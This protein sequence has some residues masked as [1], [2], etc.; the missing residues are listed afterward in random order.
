MYRITVYDN[1]HGERDLDLL[2]SSF[3]FNFES[4]D[5]AQLNDSTASWSYTITLPR[6]KRNE[7]V[8]GNA[9]MP[10]V[11]ALTPYRRVSCNVYADG[12]RIIHAGVLVID[13]TT[14]TEYKTQILAGTASV[15]DLMKA[16]DFKNWSRATQVTLPGTSLPANTTPAAGLKY[17]YPMPTKIAVSGNTPQMQTKEDD[18]YMYATPL[19][20]IGAAANTG[21]LN[22]LMAE[23]GYSFVTDTPDSVLDALWLSMATRK[24]SSNGTV[25]WS[26]SES[27]VGI[28]NVITNAGKSRR[29]HTRV[30]ARFTP[31]AY[32]DS[33]HSRISTVSV[34]SNF[35]S[36]GGSV[37][38]SLYDQNYVPG[39]PNT[40]LAYIRS[41]MFSASGNDIVATFDIDDS[42]PHTE[43]KTFGG[44][45][46]T[47]QWSYY[48]GSQMNYFTGLT[49]SSAKWKVQTI[50][51]DES[52]TA[53]SGQQMKL[54]P[55]VGIANGMDFF[56]ILSQVFGWTVKVE[57]DTKTVIAHTFAYIVGRKQY[58]P[59]WT[60]RVAM[61][62][63][64][65]ADF[66]FGSYAQENVIKLQE[67]KLGAYQD[68]G[69][70][71]IDNVNLAPSK[72]LLDIKI[73]SGKAD[74][75][76]Q[77]Q[78]KDDGSYEWKDPTTPHLIRW[79]NAGDAVAHVTATDILTNYSSLIS[80]LQE[81]V[82]IKIKMLLTPLDIYNFDQFT[83]VYLRQFGRY[84]YVNKISDWEAGKLCNVELLQLSF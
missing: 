70:F 49:L 1:T 44:A 15:F 75:I 24:K 58:A 35:V 34:L 46:G 74:R 8:L 33:H 80:V 82:L 3:P 36:A 21:V 39:Q 42:V 19:L 54:E 10:F 7:E 62:Q 81:V 23:I 65:E 57:A 66:D 73:S 78:Q 25:I 53:Y 17:S 59:D 12:L 61:D 16:V 79:A 68:T 14:K 6:T 76:E 55:N 83:P 56:K 43:Y 20:R 41:S 45:D 13:T 28:D 77:W 40:P 50:L 5:I 29:G 63:D 69:T 60:S 26:S 27:S 9:G 67:N 30:T 51:D 52:E 18:F 71:T 38:L 32:Y 22:S 84:Y 37:T 64:T 11:S 4:N 48:D 2:E 47:T 72:N 31:I